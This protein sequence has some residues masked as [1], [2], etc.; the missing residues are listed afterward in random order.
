MGNTNVK[1]LVFS[2]LM[3][4]LVVVGTMVIQVP[5]ITKGYIHIGDSMVYLCGIFLGPVYGGL[6]AG[7]GSLLADLFS[8][9][10]I[11]AP[12][13]FVIKALDAMIVGFIYL[14]LTKISDSMSKKL[15][16][17]S[18]AAFFGGLIMVSGYLAY[19][20]FLYGFNAALAGVVGN[21]TQALGGGILVAP[22]LSVMEK[23]KI[24]PNIAE[25]SI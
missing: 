10:A 15:A 17:F 14:K 13:T 11:Y 16:M 12:A 18:I 23:A 2:G 6:A 19:E 5:T 4:A 9:Y 25:R 3:A 1:K 21:I 20:S 24:V 8:G 7:I 22:I